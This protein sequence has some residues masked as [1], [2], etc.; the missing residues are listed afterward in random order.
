[1][2]D[3]TQSV[4]ARLPRIRLRVVLGGGHSLRHTEGMHLDEELGRDQA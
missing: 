1:M 2:W 3:L 4:E